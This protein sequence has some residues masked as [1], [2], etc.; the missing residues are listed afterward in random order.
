MA[1]LERDDSRATSVDLGD[2][3]DAINELE[4][5][6]DSA[7]PPGTTIV[8]HLKDRSVRDQDLYVIHRSSDSSYHPRYL[9]DETHDLGKHPTEQQAIERCQEHHDSQVATGAY[10]TIP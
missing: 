3:V 2:V 9:V 7:L 8:C 5:K 10:D 1:N 4:Q 6:L